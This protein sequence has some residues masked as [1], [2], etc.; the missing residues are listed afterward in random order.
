MPTALPTCRIQCEVGH[1]VYQH[2]CS[3]VEVLISCATYW[4]VLSPPFLCALGFY[5]M[6]TA[7]S[8]FHVITA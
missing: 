2:S 6:Q 8:T 1:S 3:A 4:Y 7:D 5:E